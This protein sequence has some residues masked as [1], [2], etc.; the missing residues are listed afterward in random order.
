MNLQLHEEKEKVEELRN[1]GR[2]SICRSRKT[3][4]R[5][6][7]GKQLGGKYCQMTRVTTA[8]SVAV[9]LQTRGG[10]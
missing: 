6:S 9:H 3:E 5:V 1:L 10:G 2:E 7:R 8:A 4:T